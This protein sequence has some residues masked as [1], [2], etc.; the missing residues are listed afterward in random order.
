MQFLLNLFLNSHFFSVSNHVPDQV[1]AI[2][3]QVTKRNLTFKVTKIFIQISTPSGQANRDGSDHHHIFPHIP[4]EFCYVPEE[5]GSLI[6]EHRDFQNQFASKGRQTSTEI[7]FDHYMR[8]WTLTPH[9]SPLPVEMRKTKV[10]WAVLDH[11]FKTG[12]QQIVDGTT[13]VNFIIYNFKPDQTLTK[14]FSIT[15]L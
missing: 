9:S 13:K 14:S 7:S 12:L 5:Y 6:E 11:A 2:S 8:K 10:D 4:R 1:S 15:S 3:R